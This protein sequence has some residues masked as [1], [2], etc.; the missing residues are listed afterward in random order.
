MP[1]SAPRSHREG[2]A[3]ADGRFINQKIAVYFIYSALSIGSLV[4]T[5]RGGRHLD[6][7]FS[8][9]LSLCQLL[10]GNKIRDWK[11]KQSRC[12]CSN[13]KGGKKSVSIRG[14]FYVFS[15]ASFCCVATLS[16]IQ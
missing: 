4:A 5:A 15:P 11:R 7:A 12:V 9:S 10:N 14:L 8:L 6:G 16:Q 1:P 3:I 2:K 13:E